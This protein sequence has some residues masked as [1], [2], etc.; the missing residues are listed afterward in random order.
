MTSTVYRVLA[1][2]FGPIL[3]IVAIVALIGGNYA[4][5]YVADQLGQEK[6]TMPAE[7]AV[8]GL[9]KA[10]QDALKPFFGQAMTNGT[11]AQAYSNH[12]IWEHM[13]EACAAVKDAAGKDLPAVPA[14][15]CTFAGIG[16]VASAATDPAAKA[17]YTAVRA[18]NFQ[19][20][21]LRSMLLT[22]YAFWLIGTIAIW[23]GVLFGLAGIALVVWGYFLKGKPAAT[24]PVVVDDR[25]TV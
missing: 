14:D 5:S 22:A 19:G 4:H 11:A 18:S 16:T 23:A 20:D 17:A 9:P 7:A 3:I 24:N 2:V 8:K 10:S 13:Q 25:V 1:K 21:A 15:K 12:Y 6:I